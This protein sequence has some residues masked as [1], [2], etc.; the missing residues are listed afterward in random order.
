MRTER[1]GP[2]RAAGTHAARRL[3]AP[4]AGSARLRSSPIPRRRR[5][6]RAQL[7][8]ARLR[9]N[10]KR[11]SGRWWQRGPVR[12]GPAGQEREPVKGWSG[13]GSGRRV[14]SGGRAQPSRSEAPGQEGLR[15]HFRYEPGARATEG[16]RAARVAPP[17]VTQRPE[18]WTSGPAARSRRRRALWDGTGCRWGRVA[19]SS[20]AAA[21]PHSPLP[22]CDC[23][24]GGAG[25][26]RSGS[27]ERV[28]SHRSPPAL[29]L[30]P[31][32]CER[33]EGDTHTRTPAHTGAL[34]EEGAGGRGQPLSSP[35]PAL[36]RRA[37]GGRGVPLCFFPLA[38]L[39]APQPQSS[40]HPLIYKANEAR[41]AKRAGE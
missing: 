2:A 35:P 18:P 21:G 8:S 29:L 9:Q 27:S 36:T 23:R 5:Q 14:E 33:S 41:R 16:A 39:E 17:G 37:P 22:Y 31:S 13:R 12:A 28:G 26:E 25:R 3:R 15:A 1:T 24:G 38:V 11:S 30:E 4:P 34:R 6:P 10:S 20:C 7:G 40:G 32:V 19:G